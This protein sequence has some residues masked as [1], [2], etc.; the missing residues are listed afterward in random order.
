MRIKVKGDYR[1][2]REKEYPP[3]GDQLDALWKLV[4]HLPQT[5][6]SVSILEEISRIKMEYPKNVN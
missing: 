1:K 4:K 2:A 3:I 5:E 6:E